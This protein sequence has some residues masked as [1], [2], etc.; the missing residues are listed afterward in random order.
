MY[1]L[2]EFTTDPL[3]RELY[4]ILPSKQGEARAGEVNSYLEMVNWLLRTYAKENLLNAHEAEFNSASQREDETETA[5]YTRLRALRSTCGY[6]HTTGQQR[7]SCR[8]SCWRESGECALLLNAFLEL[9]SSC[10][11]TLDCGV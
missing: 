9:P 3:R 7:A 10:A 1:L 4:S 8:A 11:I 6:I 5:F 2:P